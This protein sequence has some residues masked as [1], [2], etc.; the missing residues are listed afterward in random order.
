MS[1]FMESKFYKFLSGNILILF[2]VFLCIVLG[3]VK[4][5][6]VSAQNIMNVLTQVSINALL[7]TGMTFVILTGGIDLS[8]GSIAGFSG[9]SSAFLVRLLNENI[10]LDVV[11]LIALC[12]ALFAAF[13]YGSIVGFCVSKLNVAPFIA[14]LAMLSVARGFAYIISGGKPIFEV[15]E[16]YKWIG[17]Y[18]LFGVLP[19]VIL[20]MLL[21]MI[22]ANFII[23]RTPFGRHLLAI[24]S[25]EHV[26]YLS[27]VNVKKIK[28]IVYIIS[29]FTAA[30]GGII[31][32]S[33]IGT[34]QPSSAEGYELDAIAAVVLGGTSLNG[35]KGSIGKT[36]IGV[37]TIGVI[38][39]GMSLLL[40]DAY[41]QKVVMGV[42]I[43][44]AVILDQYRLR[45]K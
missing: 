33:K 8:V 42:I 38:N 10:S 37:V 24:G 39:N 15:P 44:F 28:I 32:A 36:A 14:T 1:G 27:G 16:T 45:N 30:L 25:N 17:Q 40:V 29:A 7:A 43:L 34:G 20:I 35:G 2:L 4:P 12:V 26:A 21:I 22:I 11:I 3:I 18:R 41:T 6:F 13:I 9:V 31:L 23:S 19:I 5:L